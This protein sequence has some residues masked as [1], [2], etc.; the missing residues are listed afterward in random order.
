MFE[1]DFKASPHLA[2]WIPDL[3]KEEILE[4]TGEVKE[5]LDEAT[6]GITEYD[7]NDPLVTL[8]MDYLTKMDPARFIAMSAP[9]DEYK[10]EA[11]TLTAIARN[12]TLSPDAVWAVWQYFLITDV[13]DTCDEMCAEILRLQESL[14]TS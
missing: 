5:I 2:F 11:V 14:S 8:V 9:L 13:S 10:P 12:G 4:P 1:E 6:E 3:P 7:R